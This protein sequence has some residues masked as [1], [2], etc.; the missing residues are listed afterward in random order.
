MRRS[1]HLKRK[2]T[3][4]RHAQSLRLR[5]TEESSLMVLREDWLIHFTQDNPTQR[6]L[7][8]VLD[9][10]KLSLWSDDHKGSKQ[11]ELKIPLKSIRSI[12]NFRKLRL[13]TCLDFQFSFSIQTDDEKEIFVTVPDLQFFTEQV[14]S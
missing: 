5:Q 3:I 1:F 14:R 11:C 9:T 12:T 6:R 8:W 10:R 4:R 2:S 7:K 13:T